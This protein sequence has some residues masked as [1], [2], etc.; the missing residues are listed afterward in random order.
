[1]GFDFTPEVRE[2]ARENNMHP[3]WWKTTTDDRGNASNKTPTPSN[4]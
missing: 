3:T 2:H 1:M 4:A